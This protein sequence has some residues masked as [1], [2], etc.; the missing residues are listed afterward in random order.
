MA[1]GKI[2]W[3][4]VV[5]E[6]LISLIFSLAI[7]AGGSVAAYSMFASLAENDPGA[8]LDMTYLEAAPRLATYVYVIFFFLALLA[9]TR[10]RIH[11]RVTTGS[12]SHWM[13]AFFLYSLIGLLPGLFFWLLFAAADR[14]GI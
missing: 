4:L 2:N 5:G 3:R 13:L 11:T 9:L 10:L 14:P 6:G 12:R 1:E 7:A 8:V